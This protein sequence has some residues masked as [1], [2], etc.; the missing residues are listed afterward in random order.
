MADLPR[1]PEQLLA[2]DL[3]AALYR[4][5]ALLPGITVTERTATLDGR[6]GTAFG[7]TAAG[8]TQDIVIAPATGDFIGERTRTVEKMDG[9]PAG[10]V[11]DSTSVSYGLSPAAGAPPRR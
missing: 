6:T 1:T 8:T 9:M 2:G 3:R 10:T 11:I 4:T 7:I 5:L